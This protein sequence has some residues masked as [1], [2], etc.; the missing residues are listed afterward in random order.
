MLSDS[1]RPRFGSPPVCHY[2]HD[3]HQRHDRAYPH[4]ALGP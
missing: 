3:G 4:L 1:F 2:R